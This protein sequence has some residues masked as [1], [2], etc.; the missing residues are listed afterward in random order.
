MGK[1][2]RRK[3]REAGIEKPKVKQNLGQM[4]P[5]MVCRECQ[6]PLSLYS[7]VNMNDE[8]QEERIIYIHSLEHID[9]EGNVLPSLE[10]Y[11]HEAVPVEGDPLSAETTC[12][13]CHSPDTR[14]A[15]V[16]RKAIR[17]DDP[18]G[19]G[20]VLDYS[21][22]WNCCD[23]CKVAVQKK[24]MTKLL[25]RAITSPYGNALNQPPH[26]QK[27]TREML[28]KLYNKYFASSPQGP[29]EVKIPPKQ[30]PIGK[31]GSRRGM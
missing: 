28:K 4:G 27:V 29:F 2:G 30:Q 23:E 10:P 24:L 19:T 3:A 16:P 11:D 17:I 21:S 5:Y 8:K 15:F 13:F 1:R 20:Q 26:I 18:L 31:P 14:W 25:D 9:K 7:L 6:N 22:P 12:D